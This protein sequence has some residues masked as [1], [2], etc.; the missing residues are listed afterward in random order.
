MVRMLKSDR[1]ALI[2][3]MIVALV[4]F[5][6]KIFIDS[7]DEKGR[8]ADNQKDKAELLEGTAANLD[9]V[10]EA[11]GTFDPNVVDS[12]TL[13]KYGLGSMQIRS[14]LGYRR[15]GGTFETPLAVSKLYNWSDEDVEKVLDYIV[16]G[17]EYK[18]TYKYR[19]QYEA[20][21][22]KEYAGRVEYYRAK[23]SVHN[24]NKDS[25]KHGSADKGEL[26]K[27]TR[28]DKF[29][30]LTKIDLNTAD[31]TQLKRIP[32]VGRGIANSIVKLRGKLGGFYSVKQLE[33]VEYI[34]PELYEWFEVKSTA[35]LHLI[36][37]NKASFQVLNSHPYISYNQTR[38]LMN[39]RRLYGSLKDKDD[40][41]STNIFT[42]DEVER[43]APYL[44]Y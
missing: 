29:K 6:V 27:Y 9:S 21:R 42:K 43:L 1:R 30:S 10:R 15:H 36:N 33:A 2:F 40:L 13:L 34:S 19:E 4:S 44:E 25:L 11:M 18:K 37:I 16:I 24:A 7:M 12:V 41:L 17:D 20:E 22:N 3:L 28:S 14:L 8:E 38:D 26:P 23:E 32:G 31:T 39:Y 5:C 35:D